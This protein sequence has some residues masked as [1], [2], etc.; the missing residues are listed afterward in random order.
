MDVSF[1]I[2]L[3]SQTH[4]KHFNTSH[5][6]IVSGFIQDILR[7]FRALHYKIHFKLTPSSSI[8]RMA[9]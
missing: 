8:Q 6:K 4:D 2:N 7:H 3:R 5:V 9:Q 1:G